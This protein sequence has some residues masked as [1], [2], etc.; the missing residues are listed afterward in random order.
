MTIYLPDPDVRAL[1]ARAATYIGRWVGTGVSLPSV[2][3]AMGLSVRGV[4]WIATDY[5]DEYIAA[6]AEGTE[7]REKVLGPAVSSPSGMGTM[8]DDWR[9]AA[10]PV[11]AAPHGAG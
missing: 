7:I 2:A 4:Y 6:F 10:G 9:T 5:P 11:F 1:R 3:D 8:R